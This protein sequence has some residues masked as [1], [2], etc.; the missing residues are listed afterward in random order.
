MVHIPDVL[1]DREYTQ[2]ESARLG[3][4]RTMLGV[5]LL[6]Q[7]TPIGALTVTRSEVRPFNERQIELLTTFA[8]QAVIAIENVRLFDEVQAR[9]GE[10]SEALERQTA[11]SEV[12][13]VIS[14]S[15]GELNSV[16]QTILQNAIRICEA[17]F[18]TIYQFEGDMARPVAWVGAPPKLGDYYAQRGLFRQLA[19]SRTYSTP[20]RRANW[21]TRRPTCPRWRL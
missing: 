2:H 13:R 19:T 9:T 11:T 18:G 1:A 3:H 20:R 14:S 5:P 6:R 15:P 21:L 10:L 16:F 12:L 7:G 4:W 17:T 8:D